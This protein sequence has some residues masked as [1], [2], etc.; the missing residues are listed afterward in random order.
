MCMCVRLW[1]V[2]NGCPVVVMVRQHAWCA[3]RCTYCITH[4][5]CI[6]A[7]PS[8]CCVSPCAG[9]VAAMQW[10]PGL[11]IQAVTKGLIE[12]VRQWLVHGADVNAVAV[13][14]QAPICPPADVAFTSLQLPHD[15]R[16][17]KPKGV[18]LKGPF[19]APCY[20]WKCSSWKCSSWK[21]SSWKC[22]SWKCSR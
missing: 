22:S 19:V 14:R 11:F 7:H 6:A 18:S 20:G 2:I 1:S 21:C 3:C 5:T 12:V 17:C 15:I 4:C 13:R 8:A 10:C 16:N 9:R